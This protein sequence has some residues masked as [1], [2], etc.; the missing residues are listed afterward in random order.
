MVSYFDRFFLSLLFVFYLFWGQEDDCFRK[1]NIHIPV[2][3][4]EVKVERTEP[5]SGWYSVMDLLP[6]D[7]EKRACL[8]KGLMS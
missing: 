7:W 3:M 8:W 5:R 1:I 2:T 4:M 6:T